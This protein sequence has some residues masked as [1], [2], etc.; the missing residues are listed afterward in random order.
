MK[1]IIYTYTDRHNVIVLILLVCGWIGGLF[2][3]VH[4]TFDDLQ[5]MGDGFI[6]NSGTI[7]PHDVLQHLQ[8]LDPI[9]T[10]E[11]TLTAFPVPV[12]QSILSSILKY[13]ALLI[14]KNFSCWKSK[15]FPLRKTYNE[16]EDKCF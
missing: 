6:D 12:I 11:T 7:F 1:T 9:L 3:K 14:G 16:K 5:K 10:K 4:R 15:F 8:G 2:F 13:L